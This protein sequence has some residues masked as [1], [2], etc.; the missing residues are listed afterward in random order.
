MFS[1]FCNRCYE[2]FRDADKYHEHVAICGK[3]KEVPVDGPETVLEVEQPRSEEPLPEGEQPEDNE[4]TLLTGEAEQ[5]DT[6]L[7]NPTSDTNVS[8]RRGR[9]P[10]FPKAE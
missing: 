1:R 5:Q 4:A 6:N 8:P 9:P 10:K 3:P 2:Y 7:P